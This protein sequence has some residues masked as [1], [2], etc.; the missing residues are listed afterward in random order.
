MQR[1]RESAYLALMRYRPRF[2]KGKIKFVRAEDSSGYPDDA[3]AV[4][5]NLAD[6]FEDATVPGDHLGIIT[7]HFESLGSI[8]SRYLREASPEEKG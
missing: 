6:E 7:T 4:W 2:Y 3:A 8:L 5:T 1:V